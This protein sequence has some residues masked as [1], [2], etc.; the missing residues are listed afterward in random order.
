MTETSDVIST[1]EMKQI[2]PT[3]DTTWEEAWFRL[4]PTDLKICIRVLGAAIPTLTNDEQGV[5]GEVVG[6]M[7]EA[8][9]RS[10]KQ[11]YRDAI[12]AGDVAAVLS[13]VGRTPQPAF[14]R[15]KT[16]AAKVETP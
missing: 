4:N 10:E 13:A 6:C 3:T 8:L 15:R 2:D 9:S 1:A 11:Q 5:V 14:R 12:A 16:R 7:A